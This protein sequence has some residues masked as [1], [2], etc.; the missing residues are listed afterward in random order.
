MI[1]GPDFDPCT[2]GQKIRA[3]CLRCLRP[4][5]CAAM[6]VAEDVVVEHYVL[7]LSFKQKN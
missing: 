3:N 5:L 6:Q 4:T 7:V 1:F 2:M